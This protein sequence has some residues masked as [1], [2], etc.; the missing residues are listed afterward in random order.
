MPNGYK[1]SG[2]SAY[3]IAHVITEYVRKNGRHDGL[4]H[5]RRNVSPVDV[6]T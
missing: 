3:E 5:R 1:S 2:G 4:R 6:P